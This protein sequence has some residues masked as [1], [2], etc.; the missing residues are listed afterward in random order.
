MSTKDG[1]ST[2]VESFSHWF[3]EPRGSTNVVEL[4]N[5]YFK[6]TFGKI[7]IGCKFTTAEHAEKKAAKVFERACEIQALKLTDKQLNDALHAHTECY[8]NR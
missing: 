1:A 2:D 8:R 6:A 4:G 7:T 3:G 5:G